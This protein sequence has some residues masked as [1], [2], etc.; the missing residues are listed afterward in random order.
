M[1]NWVAMN[2]RFPINIRLP[3]NEES[4]NTKSKFINFSYLVNPIV[5]DH[6]ARKINV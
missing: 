3:F 5:N 1:S 6:L 2:S 4:K